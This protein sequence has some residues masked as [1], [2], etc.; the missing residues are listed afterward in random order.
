MACPSLSGGGSLSCLL[1]VAKS[2]K[3]EKNYL[4]S[5]LHFC[6]QVRKKEEKREDERER[7][8]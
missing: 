1:P 3:R 4:I 2:D 8:S 6:A 7:K 5:L